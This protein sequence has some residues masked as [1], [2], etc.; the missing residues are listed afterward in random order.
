MNPVIVDEADKELLLQRPEYQTKAYLYHNFLGLFE[1]GF[2]NLV[3]TGKRLK[4]V[5]N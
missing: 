4:R 3:N 5:H 2:Y 1:F